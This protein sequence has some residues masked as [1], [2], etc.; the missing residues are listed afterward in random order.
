MTTSTHYPRQ[1]REA[2]ERE[3]ALH[4][5]Q[6]YRSG[7]RLA[8]LLARR[9]LADEDMLEL[10]SY[11]QP[12]QPM[13]PLLIS[14]VHYLALE[15]PRL[16]VAR[17]FAS[18]TPEPGAIEDAW[19]VFRQFCLDNRDKLIPLLATRTIQTTMVERA[20]TLLP[21]FARVQAEEG[22]AP[23]TLIE[24]GCSAGFNLLVGR[25][26]YR[27]RH[28]AS[29]S[30]DAC[31]E[32][33]APV[34]IDVVVYGNRA[35]IPAQ[36]PRIAE[37]IGIDLYPV[38]YRDPSRRNWTLA[39][40]QPDNHRLIDRMRTA[41][42]LLAEDPPRILQGDAVKVLPEVL[43]QAGPGPLCVFHSCCVYQWPAAV[44][45][46]LEAIMREHGRTRR[47]HCLAIEPDWSKQ[48]AM[49]PN[50]PEAIT[51]SA[52]DY[53]HTRYEGGRADTSHLGWVEGYARWIDWR[54]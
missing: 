10:A 15:D 39:M 1:P 16:P 25:H 2:C 51:T 9:T 38:D 20:A 12:G 29:G 37:R 35:P 31:G 23:L 22:G 40:M 18:V 43:A 11:V 26:A 6:L 3:F 4:S 41:F 45:S 32:A 48:P 27:F 33:T 47:I 53:T 42:G 34:A 50:Y 46:D 52:C 24:L 36:V 17:Y 28:E 44:R 14:V 49:L 21:G 13:P 54:A 5:E 19:P 30:V 7:S 8:P